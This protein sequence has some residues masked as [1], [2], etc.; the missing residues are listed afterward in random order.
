MLCGL[1]LALFPS[2]YEPWGYTP[3]EA[4][5][6]RVPTL[7]TTLAGFGMWVRSHYKGDHPG[8]TILDRDDNNYSEV[9][10]GVVESLDRKSV[11]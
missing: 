6:F 1:D 11:V 3:L 2:Y 10:D 4:L 5:A 9:V 8:I 7:T